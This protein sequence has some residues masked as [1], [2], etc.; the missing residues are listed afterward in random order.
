MTDA[1]LDFLAPTPKAGRSVPSLQR[2]DAAG[3][4]DRGLPEMP[5]VRAQREKERSR[6][7]PGIAEAMAD[8]WGALAAGERSAP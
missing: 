1:V 4:E 7:Y 3:G 8:Q 2:P 6:T 5:G